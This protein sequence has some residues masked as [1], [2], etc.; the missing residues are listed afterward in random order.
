MFILCSY[1]LQSCFHKTLQIQSHLLVRAIHYENCHH[2]EKSFQW[3]KMLQPTWLAEQI[4]SQCCILHISTP[5]YK[6]SISRFLVWGSDAHTAMSVD[7]L[8]SCIITSY[9]SCVSGATTKVS[10]AAPKC[11]KWRAHR[12]SLLLAQW[13][14]LDHGHAT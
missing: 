11:R 12:S 10:K 8:I 14:K 3:Y 13:K 4:I 7:E 1:C 2:L 9:S 5:P 6:K